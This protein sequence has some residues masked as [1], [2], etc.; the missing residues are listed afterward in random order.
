MR[1]AIGETDFEQNQILGYAPIE[2][3]GSFKLEVPAD[4][5][6]AL[7]VI[8]AD[9]RAIQTHT[10]WIQVRPGERRTCDG[11]HSPRRG[12]AL[13]SGVTVN[14]MPAAIKTALSAQHLSGETLA[15]LRTRLEPAAL[16]LGADPVYSDYWADTTR[17]VTPAPRARATTWP[18]PRPPMA[19]STTRT[20]LRPCG[21][22][23]AARRAARP[24]PP[25]TPMP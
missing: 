15:S 2:P 7:S 16:A 10:N 8:D 11:C 4:V 9:G 20:T 14:S 17:S 21:R 23:V 5:P 6:L 18:R 13:N 25:A 1:A 24:A 19:S 22:A 3:D 12:A